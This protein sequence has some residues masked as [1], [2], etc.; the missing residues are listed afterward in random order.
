MQ[1]SVGRSQL[2]KRDDAREL[3]RD[4]ISVKCAADEQTMTDLATYGL[5]QIVLDEYV[6]CRCY[7]LCPECKSWAICYK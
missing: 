5:C 1:N 2:A 7:Y 4:F 6:W 3:E